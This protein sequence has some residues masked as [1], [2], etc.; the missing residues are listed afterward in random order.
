MVG[1]TSISIKKYVNLFCKKPLFGPKKK[2]KDAKSGGELVWILT[3]V[4]AN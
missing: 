1:F 2:R 4:H 3:Y